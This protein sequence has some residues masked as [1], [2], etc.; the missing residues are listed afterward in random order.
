MLSCL[1]ACQYE[2]PELPAATQ[3]GANTFGCLVDGELVIPFDISK[4]HYDHSA[5]A[6]YNQ[7]ADTLLIFGYGQRSQ[8]FK[9]TLIH[10]AVNRPAP[11][12]KAEYYYAPIPYGGGGSYY[13]GE[14]IGTITLTR[15]DTQAVS[16]TFDFIGHGYSIDPAGA[17]F[18]TGG[19]VT[20]T[21]GRFD[22][23]MNNYR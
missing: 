12:D 22:I 5:R 13:G 9:F 17:V 1:V 10:P 20:V 6:E 16:G 2:I 8:A 19:S 15:F 3:T 18:D 14:R 21:M 4:D 23:T 7:T 11:I